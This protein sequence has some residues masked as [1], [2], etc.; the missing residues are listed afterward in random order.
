MYT[1]NNLE[2]VKEFKEDMMKTFEMTNLGLMNYFLGIEDETTRR[3][4]IYLSKKIYWS[5]IEES[6]ATSLLSRFMQKPS[7]IHYGVEKNFK[8]SR[9]YKGVWNIIQNHD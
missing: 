7:Q 6:L 2:I 1:G 4:H 8:I 9:R 5:P 3:R